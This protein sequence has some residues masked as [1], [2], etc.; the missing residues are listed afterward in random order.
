M[1]RANQTAQSN[2]LGKGRVYMQGDSLFTTA[3]QPMTAALKRNV[4][5]DAL[6]GRMTSV[7]VERLVDHLKKNQNHN[8]AAIVVGLGTNDV[9]THS[10]DHFRQQIAR[11]KRAIGQYAPDAR[12][13]W[14]NVYFEGHR[15]KYERYNRILSE[16]LENVVDWAELVKSGKA[17]LGDGVHP[18]DAQSYQQRWTAITEALGEAAPDDWDDLPAT[19]DGGS[20]SAGGA[21]LEDVFTAAKATAFAV[22]LQ[23]PGE[24][25]R[26]EAVGL[27]GQKS[28][29]NDKPLFDF[30]EQLAG[31]CMR[32]FMS[33]PN[34]DFYAFYPNYFG[35]FESRDPYWNIYDLELLEGGIELNDD[36][37]ATHVY[38]VGDTIMGDGV[39]MFERAT[40]A[41]TVTIYNVAQTGFDAAKEADKGEKK[42]EK[43]DPKALNFNETTQV[44]DFLAKYGARPYYEEAPNVRSQFYEAFLAYQ[45]F[46]LLWASQFDSQFK[47]TFMPELYPSGIVAFP[48]HDIQCYVQEVTHTF[49]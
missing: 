32:E 35:T 38:V 39:T 37:L 43:D 1:A 49:D 33:L 34:G 8:Y 9:R 45:R 2:S 30:V 17:R 14:V 5:V 19:T 22:E 10:G 12:L 25:D 40:A 46:Q 23:F 42:D 6:G 27:Q 3:E 11:V 36:T 31:A 21:N 26:V 44:I 20:A 18:R 4:I 29:L 15:E 48:D 28:M 24:Q 47:F 7:G 16:E 41:G 13:I